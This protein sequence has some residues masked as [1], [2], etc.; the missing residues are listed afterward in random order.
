MLDNMVRGIN[1]NYDSN[2]F[3]TCLNIS[4]FPNCKLEASL[5]VQSWAKSDELQMKFS[6]EEELLHYLI[7]LVLHPLQKYSI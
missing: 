3:F 6:F 4:L 1:L 2:H 7:G 5:A